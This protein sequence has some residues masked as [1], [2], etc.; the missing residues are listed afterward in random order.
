MRADAAHTL[1]MRRRC[2][3]A[4]PVATVMSPS[5][6]IE[7]PT[8]HQENPVGC[9]G[10]AFEADIPKQVVVET[11]DLIDGSA[12]HERFADAIKHFL[13]SVLDCDLDIMSE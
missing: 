11:P 3:D 2:A 1:S 7:R 12:M 13:I 10:M 6:A 8:C 5:V 9:A 4:W